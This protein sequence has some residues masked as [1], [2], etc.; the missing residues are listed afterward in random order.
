[1]DV[2]ARSHVLLQGGK[3]SSYSVEEEHA[4]EI[5]VVRCALEGSSPEKV[6]SKV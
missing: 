3:E 2:S 4:R 6:G 5:L 1:M